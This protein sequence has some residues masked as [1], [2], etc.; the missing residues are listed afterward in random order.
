MTAIFPPIDAIQEFSEETQDADARYGRGNGGTINA[1]I[2][3]GTDKY[4]GDVFE[5]LRNTALDARNYFNTSGPQAKPLCGKTSLASP[6]ADRS[7]TSRPTPRPSSL[8]TMPESA[9]LR[10]RRMW[11]AYRLSISPQ[12][13]MTFPQLFS[14]P[15]KNPLT[16]HVAYTKAISSPINDPL[17]DQTG[18]NILN[19]YQKYAQPNYGQANAVANNFFYSPLLII[20]EDDFD[21]KI[22]RKFTEKDSAFLR[23]SQGHDIFSQ[24]G[25]LPTPLVGDV[26]CGPASDPAHQ[27]V[28]SETHIFSPTIINTARYGWTRFFVYAQELGCGPATCLPF[29]PQHPR[30]IQ[31]EQSSDRRTA[32]DDLHGLHADRRRGQQ[33][34]ATSEPTTINGTTI[35]PWFAAST[36]WTS[37][38]I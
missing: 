23:Y 4:H 8:P 30:R 27:A 15:F 1:V 2:K 38:S 33:P 9:S 24:P 3:S 5:F 17:I 29:Q 37:A 28:L 35:S 16:K 21:V 20:N 22:D 18:A 13:A 31:S 11:R 34:H 7:F 10:A 26:I 6:S 14:Q 19:F 32:G 25:V 12:R 36:R